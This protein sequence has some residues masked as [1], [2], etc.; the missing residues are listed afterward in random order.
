M[1][2]DNLSKKKKCLENI[3]TSKHLKD[4]RAGARQWCGGKLAGISTT[5]D[6]F[7]EVTPP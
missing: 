3:L 6:S 5:L 2:T 1:P 4:L 7:N